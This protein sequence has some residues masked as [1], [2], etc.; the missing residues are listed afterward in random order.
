MSKSI[1]QV[2][3][4]EI[5]T[6]IRDAEI[7]NFQVNAGEYMGFI[8]GK[9]QTTNT[10]LNETVIKLLEQAITTNPELITLYWGGELSEKISNKIFNSISS[11]YPNIEIEL[12]YG[13]QD[14]YHFLI[15]VE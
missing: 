4:G 6:A 5:V 8:N 11:A 15:S 2:T 9:L 3:S 7:D 1:E 14:Y 12:V 10:T 13:G